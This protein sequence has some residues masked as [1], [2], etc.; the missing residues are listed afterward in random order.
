[1]AQQDQDLVVVVTR[2]PVAET[3]TAHCVRSVDRRMD[4]QAGRSDVAAVGNLARRRSRV[5]VGLTRVGA[6]L[7]G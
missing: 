1:M 7:C 6:D 5:L 2:C 3:R 4:R